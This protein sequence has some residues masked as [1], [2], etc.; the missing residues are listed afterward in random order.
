VHCGVATQRIRCERAL[1]LSSCNVNVIGDINIIQLSPKDLNHGV[2][3]VVGV[4]ERDVER[5]VVD[6]EDVVF[7]CVVY[8]A[9][10]F[11]GVTLNDSDKFSLTAIFRSTETDGVAP[12]VK[13]ARFCL[14]TEYQTGKFINLFKFAQFKKPVV[15]SMSACLSVRS[16][17]SKTTSPNFTNFLYMLPV[18]VARSSFDGNAICDIGLS[19]M[20]CE[21][22]RIRQ[23]VFFVQFARWRHP[24]RSLPSPIASCLEIQ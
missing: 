3:A 20:W 5:A 19:L 2:G 1:S 18:A 4:T 7:R 14:R 13:S 23:R 11:G 16:H 21:W 6:T 15:R 22:I 12:G 24:R 10:L 8:V 17:I 9:S